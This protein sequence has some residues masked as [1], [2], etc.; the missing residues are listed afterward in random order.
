[1]R[2]YIA[3]FT[4]RCGDTLARSIVAANERS[5]SAKARKMLYPKE[6][7]G[8]IKKA[9]LMKVNTIYPAL[10]NYEN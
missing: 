5:A 2:T 10:L 1:M 8:R 4:T 6:G 9:D 7:G 3:E